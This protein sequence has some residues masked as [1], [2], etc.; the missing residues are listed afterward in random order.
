MSFYRKLRERTVKE[1]LLDQ[2]IEEGV[3]PREAAEWLWDDFGKRVR[4]DWRSIKKAVLG[5]PDITSQDIAVFMIENGIEP[6]EGAWDVMSRPRGG[7]PGR[8]SRAS[9]GD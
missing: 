4:P 5:D 6:R 3:S 1:V 7:L 2:M 8:L 9:R